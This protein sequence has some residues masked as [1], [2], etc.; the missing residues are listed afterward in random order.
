[1]SG[2][3]FIIMYTIVLI[4]FILILFMNIQ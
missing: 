2:N 3:Y 4:S 1:M